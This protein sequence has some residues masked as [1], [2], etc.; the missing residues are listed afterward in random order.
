MLQIDNTKMINLTLRIN[1]K[2]Q[3]MT[4]AALQ[5]SIH[6]ASKHVVLL[7]YV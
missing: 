2:M 7:R 5:A 4:N 1:C 3:H 6:A